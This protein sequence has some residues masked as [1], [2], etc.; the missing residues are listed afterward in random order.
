MAHAKTC[1]RPIS[2][3]RRLAVTCLVAGLLATGLAGCAAGPDFQRPSTP[4]VA[5]YT[6]TP[7]TDRTASAPMQLGETQR[8][9]EGLAIETQWWRS[10]GSPALDGLIADALHASPALANLS[11]NMRQ[12]QELLAAQAGSTQ[13]PQADIALGS[14]R[15]QISPSSQGLSGDGRQFNLHNAGVGVHYNL[16]LAGGNRRALE[17]LAARVDYRRFELNTAR[18]T[19]AGNLATAAI[20]RARLAAQL[21][22]T[23]TILRMQNEQLRLAHERV[24]IGQASP[25]EALSLQTEAEQTRAKLPELRKQLQQTEHLLAV[26]AGRAPG[27]R[28]VPGFTL[29]N[30]TLPA[31]L[32]LVVPSELVRRRPDIQA[33]EALLQAANAD[34][35]VAV[36]KLYPQINLSASLGSQALTSG[37]L[38]GGGSAVWGLL[39]NSP[40][41]FL[42]QGCLL[43]KGPRSPLSMPQQPIIRASYWSLCVTSPIPCARCKAMHRS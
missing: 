27:A 43:K 17:A 15:Q 26:L 37:A 30:F 31:E 14:Q 7:V 16:D 6:A 32:P 18:L 23:A 36:A 33:A 11:A 40:S 19:L 21:D 42:M 4:D 20:T 38:F 2:L 28:G 39:R 35:G 12:A 10:L 24:R 25:D 29:E 34:Y 22:V 13:Y 8:L 1:Q 41:L 9:V 3:E 5:R